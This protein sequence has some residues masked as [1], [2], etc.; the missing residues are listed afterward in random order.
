MPRPCHL[1]LHKTSK[2]C[3]A[4]SYSLQSQVVRP[5]SDYTAFEQDENRAAAKQNGRGLMTAHGSLATA[6]SVAQPLNV[7]FLPCGLDIQR[8]VEAALQAGWNSNGTSVSSSKS[9][10]QESLLLLS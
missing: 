2:I 4:A 6:C 10:V 7:H 1:G 3:S 8:P 5:L 9:H